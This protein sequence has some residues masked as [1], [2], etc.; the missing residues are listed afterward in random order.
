MDNHD[1]DHLLAQRREAPLPSLAPAFQQGVWREVRRRKG[2][3]AE[4]QATWLGWL[5]EPMFRPAMALGGLALAVVIGV[6]LGAT[7]L[8]GSPQ[9]RTRLV[10]DLQVFGSESPSLPATLIGHAK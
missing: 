4:R 6:G 5:L 2:E 1:L 8:A 10:L 3:I 9:A 7:A